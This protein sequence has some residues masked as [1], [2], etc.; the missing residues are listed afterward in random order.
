MFYP[1]NLDVL[2]Q[3]KEG[4]FWKSYIIEYKLSTLN[5]KKYFEVRVMSKPKIIKDG[6]ILS[7]RKELLIRKNI[8]HRY[9]CNIMTHFHDYMHL[10]LIVDFP[11][12]GYLF[13]LLNK[14]KKI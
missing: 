7:M 10:Y 6:L 5:Y 1:S 13:Y 8:F 4:L 3:L 12:G 9:L 2:Y 11:V 14:K